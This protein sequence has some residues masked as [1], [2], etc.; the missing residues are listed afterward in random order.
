MLIGAGYG[1]PAD[2]WSTACMVRETKIKLFNKQRICKQS[3]ATLDHNYKL[4]KFTWRMKCG[5]D[6]DTLLLNF[7]DIFNFKFLWC[8]IMPPSQVLSMPTKNV[9]HTPDKSFDVLI[10]NTQINMFQ[11]NSERLVQFENNLKVFEIIA[12]KTSGSEC[13]F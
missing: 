3:I 12:L 11:K 10:C 9:S 8:K 6:E 13:V 1:P 5:S 7:Q 4:Y 2:I